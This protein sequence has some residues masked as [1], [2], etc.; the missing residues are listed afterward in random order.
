MQEKGEK[1]KTFRK[2]IKPIKNNF[3]LKKKKKKIV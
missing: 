1:K 3:F 2:K